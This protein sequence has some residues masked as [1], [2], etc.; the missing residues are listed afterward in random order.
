MERST[1]TRIVAGLMAAMLFVVLFPLCFGAGGVPT[2]SCHGEPIPTKECGR[3]FVASA[4]A[5]I[6]QATS[7]LG[8]LLP[9]G[10]VATTDA[11]LQ[12][13]GS[14]VAAAPLHPPDALAAG[15]VIRI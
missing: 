4:N 11:A 9:V 7:L 14:V 10:A 12:T 1:T 15:V 5:C 13:P 6:Q 3:T 8:G 2:S